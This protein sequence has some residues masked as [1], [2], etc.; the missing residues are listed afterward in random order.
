M[1]YKLKFWINCINPN[2]YSS[3]SSIL[4]RRKLTALVVFCLL[5]LVDTELPNKL[6]YL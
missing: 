2:Y 4:E 1:P 6:Y 5:L 3:S